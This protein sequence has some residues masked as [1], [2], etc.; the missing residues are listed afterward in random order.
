MPKAS[1]DKGNSG[2]RE[3][4][5]ILG[6]NKVSAM[7]KPGADLDWN[8]YPVEVKRYAKPVSKKIHTILEE[9][10][11]LVERCDRGEWIAHL[12]VT[13]LLDLMETQYEDT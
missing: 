3:I 7:Y 1:R 13:D 6:A 4:A 5:K 10:P 8:G 12:R 2:E 11:I 9:V